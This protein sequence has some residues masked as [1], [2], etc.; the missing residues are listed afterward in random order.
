MDL[1]DHKENLSQS[2]KPKK[3]I[4]Y[5]ILGVIFISY[6]I[7]VFADTVILGLIILA[8]GVAI[9]PPVQEAIRKHSKKTLHRNIFKLYMWVGIFAIILSSIL[10]GGYEAN[11]IISAD[12]PTQQA[13]V[14]EEQELTAN[15][16]QQLLLSI[17]D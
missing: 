14:I 7:S 10:Q 4:L 3:P 11:T 13:K 17:T 2:S 16:K 6:S 15:E 5:W 8:L 12:S 1:H 9:L